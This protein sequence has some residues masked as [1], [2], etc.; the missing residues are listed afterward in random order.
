MPDRRQPRVRVTAGKEK[1]AEAIV[2]LML[3]LLDQLE[4]AD[5]TPVLE[6]AREPVPDRSPPKPRRVRKKAQEDGPS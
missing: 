5:G 1:T 2:R 3:L 6:L 4:A